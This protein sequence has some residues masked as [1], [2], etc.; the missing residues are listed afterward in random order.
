[1]QIKQIGIIES[2]FK[3]ASGT[4]IQP[5]AA[6]GVRGKVIIREEY[7]QGLRDLDGFERIWLIYYFDRSCQQKLMVKPYLDDIER[8]VFSTRAPCRPNPIGM[9]CVRLISIDKKILE[10]E[11]VDILDGTPLLDIKPYAPKFDHYE[12]SRSGWLNN[13]DM[14]DNKADGR[15]EK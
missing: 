3:E 13:I 2:P 15:F 5:P 6:K 11:D 12:V 1:M 4:P 10:I 8:G 9:S 7:S 14:K